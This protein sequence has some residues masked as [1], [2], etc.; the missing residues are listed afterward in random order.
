MTTR[1]KRVLEGR[2][3]VE[4]NPV[5]GEELRATEPQRKKPKKHVVDSSKAG[6][7]EE[8]SEMNQ[9]I[10]VSDMI[11]NVCN[12]YLKVDERATGIN[13]CWMF[14][15]CLYKLI[16]LEDAPDISESPNMREK[17]IRA[18]M[19]LLAGIGPKAKHAFTK[20]AD[21]GIVNDPE[22]YTPFRYASGEP[23]T[24]IPTGSDHP[25]EYDKEVIIKDYWDKYSEIWDDIVGTVPGSN[26][27]DKSVM[28]TIT[29]QAAL[30][31]AVLTVMKSETVQYIEG[32]VVDILNGTTET[33]ESAK[34]M[35]S[36]IE[37]LEAKV[38]K[39]VAG[40]KKKK[41]PIRMRKVSVGHTLPIG[42]ENLD[43]TTQYQK[44]YM[45]VKLGAP[46]SHLKGNLNSEAMEVVNRTHQHMGRL[47]AK[48]LD[49]DTVKR[50]ERAEEAGEEAA[51]FASSLSNAIFDAIDDWKRKVA[52]TETSGMNIG[53]DDVSDELQRVLGA[54][55]LND[56]EALKK[57]NNLANEFSRE[58]V[59]MISDWA[60]EAIGA[61]MLVEVFFRK[62]KG[63]IGASGTNFLPL[64][65]EA[66]KAI[67]AAS[68]MEI[69]SGARI[70][71]V[72]PMVTMPFHMTSSEVARKL[73]DH[74]A[75]GGITVDADHMILTNSQFLLA[76]TSACNV[77]FLNSAACFSRRVYMKCAEFIR[78]NNTLFI[79][80]ACEHTASAVTQTYVILNWALRSTN[81][82]LIYGSDESETEEPKQDAVTNFLGSLASLQEA[83]KLARELH[84]SN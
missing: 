20:W 59:N 21:Q 50:V 63:C 76:F 57:K 40:N 64:M 36:K 26:E 65:P 31:A 67:K 7:W 24:F 41:D 82:Y 19:I 53:I 32:E 34:E 5:V 15:D 71:I 79:K 66:E 1:E 48:Y 27:E 37:E 58:I 16:N 81:E 33:E 9:K 29:S 2:T 54:L 46:T 73:F 39:H 8:Y 35:N 14:L 42:V 6:M 44:R 12:S 72:N 68:G 74:S 69:D 30:I 84:E 55:I 11:I 51:A 60:E 28:R 56:R 25:N 43:A 62:A 23:I 78:E 13:R 52:Q 77:G 17:T 45:S 22:L 80:D 47:D 3:D 70:V 18:I 61:K 83:K 49:Y 38:N 10:L 4:G 75:Y